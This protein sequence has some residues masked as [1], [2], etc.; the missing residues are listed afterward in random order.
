M[1]S[2]SSLAIEAEG[3]D[4]AVALETVTVAA[5]SNLATASNARDTAEN[6][7]VDCSAVCSYTPLLVLIKVAVGTPTASLQLSTSVEAFI[8]LRAGNFAGVETTG[9]MT[10]CPLSSCPSCKLTFAGKAGRSYTDVAK[11]TR[12]VGAA[13]GR[14]VVCHSR[15]AL[16][17][18]ALILGFDH[19]HVGM[20]VR[21]ANEQANIEVSGD[22]VE[23]RRVDLGH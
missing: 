10:E 9:T 3:I 17:F 19:C 6:Y 22:E 12:H 2:G 7:T 15:P 14:G 4:A 13:G 16:T 20:T 5:S 18:P 1:P 8:G 23:L 11:N 21:L